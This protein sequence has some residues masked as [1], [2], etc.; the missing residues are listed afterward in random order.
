MFIDIGASKVEI[1][2]FKIQI[3]LHLQTR[4]LACIVRSPLFERGHQRENLSFL[5]KGP[6]FSEKGALFAIF[7]GG[8]TGHG[9]VDRWASP[10]LPAEALIKELKWP[11]VRDM[12]RSETATIVFKSANNLAPEYLSHLFIKKAQSDKTFKFPCFKNSVCLS[13]QIVYLT[14][15]PFTCQKRGLDRASKSGKFCEGK[16]KHD[17]RSQY[18]HC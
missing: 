12:I 4:A 13:K 3:W 14:I 5:Q 17:P 7:W 15:D 6:F 1:L 16:Q 11:T 10:P 8:P 18:K 9:P 2:F